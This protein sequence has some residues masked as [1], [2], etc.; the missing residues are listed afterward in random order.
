MRA[1]QKAELNSYMASELV[2]LA[3]QYDAKLAGELATDSVAF[4]E[5]LHVQLTIASNHYAEKMCI[6]HNILE[7][8]LTAW[9]MRITRAN[10]ERRSTWRCTPN[11]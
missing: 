4:D 1:T 2:N 7:G 6:A 8:K 11:N 9:I 3:A 10:A 5:R